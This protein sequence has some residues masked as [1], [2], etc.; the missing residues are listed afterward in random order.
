[1]NHFI[2]YSNNIQK[3]YKTVFR[4]QS[5]VYARMRSLEMHM[6][7]YASDVK[8]FICHFICRCWKIMA[9][10]TQIFYLEQWQWDTEIVMYSMFEHVSSLIYILRLEVLCVHNFW[11]ANILVSFS[12]AYV[13][14]IFNSNQLL[15]Y[16]CFKTLRKIY[17]NPT[18]NKL[19]IFLEC[20]FRSA[21]LFAGTQ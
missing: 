6:H 9:I 15:V 17:P 21:S 18:R 3:P 1:M 11:I 12:A 13:L 10:R 14:D 2:R 19:K 20:V 16:E 5:R 8:I 7:I 4:R